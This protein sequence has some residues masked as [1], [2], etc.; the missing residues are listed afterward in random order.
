MELRQVNYL[1]VNKKIGS[2]PDGVFGYIY[3]HSFRY[4]SDPSKLEIARTKLSPGEGRYLF[5]IE[6]ISDREIRLV[7]YVNDESQ[8]VINDKK[9]TNGREIILF[10]FAYKEFKNLVYIALNQ[11]NLIINERNIEGDNGNPINV[12]EIK[13][14]FKNLQEKINKNYS[15]RLSTTRWWERTWVQIIILLSAIATIIGLVL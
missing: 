7:G 8:L 6:K 5:R 13:R 14:I 12:L 2:L 4:F 15:K 10:P 9:N 3:A 11:N 1:E